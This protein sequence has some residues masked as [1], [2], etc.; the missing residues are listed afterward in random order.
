MTSIAPA[1]EPCGTERKTGRA[2]ESTK[3]CVR[4]DRYDLRLAVL[5]EHRLVKDSH[6]HRQ[7]QAHG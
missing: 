6:R 7:T 2:V 1:D 3:D 4:S 5:V